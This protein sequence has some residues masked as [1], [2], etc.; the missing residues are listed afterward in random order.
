[1]ET[2][3]AIKNVITGLWWSN[4][5]GWVDHDA[6]TF[7]LENEVNL[8]DLPIEGAWTIVDNR[9]E[10]IRKHLEGITDRHLTASELW[11]LSIIDPDRQL[12]S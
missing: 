5:L 8:F 3:F 6:A 11:I 9:L 1:M 12:R 7:F 2:S 10:K 4:E